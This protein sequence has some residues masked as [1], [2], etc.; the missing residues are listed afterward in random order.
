MAEGYDEETLTHIPSLHHAYGQDGFRWY[1]SP[2]SAA[3]LFPR[4]KTAPTGNNLFVYLPGMTRAKLIR[5][6]FVA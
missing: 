3:E 5:A 4:A 2:E 1:M 6:G